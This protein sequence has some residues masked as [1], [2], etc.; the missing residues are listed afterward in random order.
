MG[1]TKHPV[2]CHRHNV[3]GY[4]RL[5]CRNRGD[6][7]TDVSPEGRT[8]GAA[9]CAYEYFSSGPDGDGCWV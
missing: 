6:G 4:S 3:L 7:Q 2:G 5:C 8:R 1:N 9:S